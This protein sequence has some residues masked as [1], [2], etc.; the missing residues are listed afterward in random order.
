MSEMVIDP[1][2][3]AQAA[4]ADPSPATEPPP[5]AAV[6]EE[7]DPTAGLDDAE[8]KLQALHSALTAARGQL[9][10]MKPLAQKA[11]ALEQEVNQFRPYAQFLQQ[12]PH[13]LQQ[14]QQQPAPIPSSDDPA[15]VELA[16]TLDLYD[17]TTGK[18]DTARAEKIRTLT[19]TEAAQIAQQAIAPVQESNYEARA[20][21][22]VQQI[23]ST[24]K[25]GGKPV[26]SQY[27]AAAIRQI[28]N[29]V[30][31]SE[32]MRILADPTVANFVRLTAA[33]LQAEAMGQA[34]AVPTLTAPALHVES[35]GGGTEYTLSDSSRKLAKAAGLNEQA[36]TA[37]AKKYVPGRSNILED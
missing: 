13:L 3:P 2:I 32:A 16:R 22:N 24:A 12:N 23:M 8:A 29:H 21:Q 28:T 1:D 9:R 11:H 30:P 25:V 7:D 15:L 33:G 35:A 5:V 26:E 27:L 6:A 17:A 10:E 14:P 36:F 20:G 34:P 18:P 37:R 31:R 4:P 19:R